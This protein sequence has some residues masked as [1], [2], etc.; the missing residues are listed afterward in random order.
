VVLAERHDVPVVR[1]NLIVD[2]RHAADSL[3]KPG[4]SNLALAMISEGIRTRDA[5]TWVVVGDLAVIEPGI[6]KLDW[7]EVRVLDADGTVLR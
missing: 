2:A 3:A 7:G 5:L 1:L 4:T 6:R